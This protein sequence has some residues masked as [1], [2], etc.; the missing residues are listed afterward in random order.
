MHLHRSTYRFVSQKSSADGH[1]YRLYEIC[2]KMMIHKKSLAKFYEILC[3]TLV[4]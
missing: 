2:I 3:G 4:P 1:S